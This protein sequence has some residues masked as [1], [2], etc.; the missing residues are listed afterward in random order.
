MPDP[1]RTSYKR[2]A[3]LCVQ[4]FAYVEFE[5]DEQVQRAVALSGTVV[6]GNDNGVFIAKSQPPGGGGGRG[7]RGGRGRGGLARGGG[8][9][10]EG[11]QGGKGGRGQDHDQHSGGRGGRGRGE[12][13]RPGLGMHPHRPSDHPHSHLDAP[14]GDPSQKR[15]PA[16][17]VP[18]A[19]A[20]PRG[21][22]G[23]AP[24]VPDH[25]MSNDEFRKMMLGGKK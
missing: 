7:G 25:P 8:S 9:H 1:C 19:V 3:S 6:P 12:R 4:N 15:G 17:F 23:G 2:V 11:R 10:G 16:P 20:V 21:D 18:R 14:M 5:S 22:G 24:P 13:G